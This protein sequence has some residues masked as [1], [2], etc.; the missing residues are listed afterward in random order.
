[1]VAWVDGEEIES[2]VD[3]VDD[4]RSVELKRNYAERKRRRRTRRRSR[5][6][7]KMNCGDLLKM[8]EG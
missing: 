8:N 2:W 3:L 1:M 5:D 7:L 6:E 4:E